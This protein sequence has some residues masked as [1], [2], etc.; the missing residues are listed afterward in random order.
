LTGEVRTSEE[1][2][3]AL[4][5]A[6]ATKGV[7]DVVDHIS[8]VPGEATAPTSGRL[9]ELPADM[10]TATMTDAGIT[11]EIE[12]KLLADPFVSGLKIDVDQG[13]CGDAEGRPGYSG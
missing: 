5:I 3:R 6:R 8:V 10:T 7:A 12:T 9:D 1:E 2:A 4:Q 13:P 11:T